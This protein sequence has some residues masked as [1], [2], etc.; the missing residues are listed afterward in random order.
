MDFLI[1]AVKLKVLKF[2]SNLF[3]KILDFRL[4]KLKGI[5]RYLPKFD[6]QRLFPPKEKDLA[7]EKRRRLFILKRFSLLTILASV[8]MTITGKPYNFDEVSVNYADALYVPEKIELTGA[9]ALHNFEPYPN[10]K[11]SL[12]FTEYPDKIFYDALGFSVPLSFDPYK[13]KSENL[14]EIT[15][16]YN[17]IDFSTLKEGS[18][19]PNL[20]PVTFANA[21]DLKES[22]VYCGKFQFKN[23]AQNLQLDLNNRLHEQAEIITYKDSFFL[24]IGPVKRDRAQL[25]LADIKN[26]KTLPSC[27]VAIFRSIK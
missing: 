23:L 26:K 12:E 16:L 3:N 27:V 5:L 7:K 11:N 24:K 10:M 15:N 20:K 18:F 9:P 21:E 13:P 22:F 2:L 4:R 14:S 1:F 19:I 17:P 6:L 8:F 25:L